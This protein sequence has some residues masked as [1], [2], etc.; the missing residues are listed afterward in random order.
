MPDILLFGAT[1]Y[2]GRLTA[3]A[4]ARRG[5]DFA[6]A[7]RNR[8][9]LEKLASETDGPE[10]RVAAVGDTDALV[11][12]LDGV[13]T[14]ITCVGPF[15]HLGDTAVEAALEAKCHYIDST[16]EGPFIDSLVRE[17][18][19]RARAAGIAMAPAVGFDEVPADVT[20]TLA[21]E[22]MEKADLTMTY[23]VPSQ[24]S[25]GTAK[26]VIDIITSPGPWIVDG[27]RVDIR[28]GEHSRWSPMPTP[29]GP[30]FAVSFP[31]AE[32][33]LAPL[34]LDIE[35]LRLYVTVGRAQAL[36]LKG[37]PLAKA[38]LGLPGVRSGLEALIEKTIAGPEG[39]AREGKWTILAEARAGDQRRNVVL[40]GK[41]V[42]GIT[43]ETLS[44]AAVRMCEA[45]FNETGVISP[46][47]A[48]G[49]DRA[50]KELIEHGVSIDTY[51]S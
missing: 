31:L 24:P 19:A 35:S 9:K 45:D 38:A 21:T 6:I 8:S 48:I 1:G 51:E 42:Y 50:Q 32:G 40:S 15:L 2:T 37:L 11:D 14:M 17:Q 43:A 44:A 30:R 5:A 36:G 46:V 3:H 39:K 47:Q 29:L 34:H 49:I 20:A 23:S 33:L 27:E 25:P 10:I 16:G 12:A 4:L 41:D 18:D 26:T 13:K 7:G 22:G 28:A